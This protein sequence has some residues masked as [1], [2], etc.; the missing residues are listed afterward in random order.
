[1]LTEIFK[2][3]Q[4]LLNLTLESELL[5]VA[6]PLAIATAVILVYFEKYKDESPG[7]NTYV[8]NSL[9]LLFVSMIMLRAIYT[10]NSLGALNYVFFPI[11]TVVSIIVFILGV[12][13][14]FLNFEHFL[15]ERMAR[16]ISSPLTLNLI[17][18]TLLI[19]VF[20]DKPN[21]WPLSIAFIILF[22]ALLAILNA[23]R[24]GI[25][26]LFIKLK[27]LKEK[28]RLEEILKEKRDINRKKQEVKKIEKKVKREVSKVKKVKKA[29]KKEERQLKNGK[30]KELEKQKKQAIKLKKIVKNNKVK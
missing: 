9:V 27:K 22:I 12:I 25:R 16:N 7:W 20:T 24:I 19:F 8:A 28:E 13:I 6:L 3:I 4:Y 2:D 1:M 23:L 26:K 30:L 17:A 18:Y 11:K 5:W 21:S 10:Y 29:L 15:P 14:L